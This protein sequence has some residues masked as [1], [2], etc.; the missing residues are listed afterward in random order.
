MFIKIEK[1]IYTLTFNQENDFNSIVTDW[2]YVDEASIQIFSILDVYNEFIHFYW[3]CNLNNL[4]VSILLQ[5][6]QIFYK[7]DKHSG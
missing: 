5:W 1:L 7:H 4:I 2:P 3:F 6:L